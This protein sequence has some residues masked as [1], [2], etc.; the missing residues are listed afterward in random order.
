MIEGLSPVWQGLLGTLFT[1]GVTALGAAVV[2]FTDT[3]G[4]ESAK[5][6]FLDGSLGFAA[7]VMLAASYWSLLA[8]AIEMSED[9]GSLAFLPASIG[10]ILGGVVVYSGELFL[11]HIGADGHEI[12]FITSVSEKSTQRTPD[13]SRSNEGGVDRGTKSSTLRKRHGRNKSGGSGLEEGKD[14]SSEKGI[15]KTVHPEKWRSM[16][17]LVAAITIHNFPEGLAVGVGFGA[18]G[19]SASATFSKA[20]NVAIGIGLQ[21]FPEGLAVSMPLRRLG[22]SRYRAFWWGQLSGVVEPVGGV[23][24]YTYIH[25]FMYLYVCIY[26]YI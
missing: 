8:P 25:I 17:L 13:V 14:S 18:I 26:I 23:Y 5:Q 9:Y 19:K 16:M 20:R 12:G 1:W 4:G 22:F 3:C 15:Q 6:K 7:G 2:F 11:E 10:F 24:I 21:N